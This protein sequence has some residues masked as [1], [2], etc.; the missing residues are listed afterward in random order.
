LDVFFKCLA[1][2]RR[3]FDRLL[4]EDISPYQA[5][6]FRRSAYDVAVS[7]FEEV[8]VEGGVMMEQVEVGG[9]GVY[10]S[11][12]EKGGGKVDLVDFAVI[13]V[14]AKHFNGAFEGAAV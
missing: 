3:T 14:L 7:P 12:P 9:D 4:G 11:F 13:D 2:S 1:P 8:V 10:G 6:T 5:E